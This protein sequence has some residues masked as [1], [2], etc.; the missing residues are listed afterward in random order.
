M[1][2]HLQLQSFPM[3]Y[4]PNLVLCQ[5]FGVECRHNGGALLT[6]KSRVPDLY[7]IS[8]YFEFFK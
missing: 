7:L 8:G 1:G 3:V 5:V 2:P 6:V 4:N